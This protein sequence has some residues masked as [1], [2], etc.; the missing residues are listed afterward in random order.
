MFNVDGDPLS[1]RGGDRGEAGREPPPCDVHLVA[2]KWTVTSWTSHVL[3]SHTGG[4]QLC[5]SRLFSS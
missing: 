5:L 2:T 1:E 4:Y 3:N